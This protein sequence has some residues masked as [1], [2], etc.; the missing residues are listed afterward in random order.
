MKKETADSFYIQTSAYPGCIELGKKIAPYLAQFDIESATRAVFC[1]NSWH[2]NRSSQNCAYALNAALLGIEQ[3]GSKAITAYDSFCEFY[4]SISDIVTSSFPEDEVLP[5][6][7]HT[8]I[9]FHGKWYK[10]LHGCGATLEYPRLF[11]ADSIIEDSDCAKEFTEMLE[12]VEKMSEDLDGGGWRGKDDSASELSLPSKEYWER[13][14]K[15]MGNNPTEPLSKRAI[16]TISS[17]PTYVENRQFVESNNKIIPLFCPSLLTDYLNYYTGTN[18]LKE[19][20]GAINKALLSQACNLYDS[21]DQQSGS[22]VAYPLFEVNEEPIIGCPSTFLVVSE[23]K[24]I[25]LFYN[26]SMGVD[27]SGL[28]SL[29]QLFAKETNE[30]GI[31]DYTIKRGKRRKLI[32]T[33]PSKLKLTIVAYHDNVTMPST[34]LIKAKPANADFQCGAVEI[35]AI[36]LMAKDIAEISS[37]FHYAATSPS[38]RVP[39]FSAASDHFSLWVQNDRHIVNGTEDRH[40]NLFL[41]F[42][43]N[44]TDRYFRDFFQKKILNYPLINNR[45]WLLESPFALHFR[46]NERG[47]S[48]IILKKNGQSEGLLKKLPGAGIHHACYLHLRANLKSAE[49]VPL[50]KAEH[51]IEVFPLLQDLIMCMAN[52]LESELGALISEWGYLRLEYVM[53]GGEIAGGIQTIDDTLAIKGSVSVA[54]YPTVM[55]SA[56]SDVFCIALAEAR[57]R[58]IE[59]RLFSAIISLIPSRSQNAVETIQSKLELLSG[60]NKMVDMGA[61]ELPYLWHRKSDQITIDNAAKAAALKTVAYAIEDEGIEPGRYFGNDAN[62]AIRRFQNSLTESFEN[63]LKKFTKRDLLIKLYETL[64]DYSHTYYV[65][66]M[67]F[68]SFSNLQTEEES[69]V[70]EQS[71]S[72]RENARREMRAVMFSIETLLT[73]DISGDDTASKEDIARLIAIGDQL[74]SASDAADMLMFNPR[75][76]GI[77]IADNCVASIVEDEHLVKRSWDIRRRQILDRGHVGSSDTADEDYIKLSCKAFEAD[78]EIPFGFFLSVLDLLAFNDSNSNKTRF[79]SPNVISVDKPAII[80]LM[81]EQF[82]ESYSR[83]TLEKCIDFLTLDNSKLKYVG[84]REVDYLPF[85]RMKDRPNR[86]ELKPLVTFGNRLYYSPVQI[87]L[88]KRRWMQG[89]AERFIPAK[90]AFN[91]LNSVM[92]NWKRRY[93]KALEKDV[94]KCFIRKGFKPEHVFRGLELHKKG[95]HPRNLGDYDGLAYDASSETIWVIECKEFEKIESAFDY[96]QLQHRWFGEKGKLLHFERRIKYLRDNLDAVALDLG[97]EHCEELKIQAYLVSNKIFTN[98]IGESSF[99][100]ISLAELEKLLDAPKQ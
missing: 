99:Q 47:F 77:E 83:S 41:S 5:V 85:G 7:G 63:Q 33:K 46:D 69:R 75:N 66:T 34:V 59:C 26:A 55:F 11:F 68:T 36:L 67:R 13:V 82:G 98:V 22:V 90:K 10:A 62:N 49:G 56:S 17:F 72:R 94:R 86:F 27:D 15:W 6:M 97:F 48:E 78:T 43:Y 52:S 9:P 100:V 88:L 40:G 50:D 25:T 87:G 18:A 81:S 44:E 39:D 76:M 61:L 84:D 32:V 53:P 28:A 21:D 35:M 42:D 70:K 1:I 92:E 93:E 57:D 54:T 80:D 91:S 3:F 74:L 31:L 58:S 2:Q 20:Q 95:S 12:Y 8:L 45:N 79:E 23:E 24:R 19:T 73:L 89:I 16:K 96:M 37:F 38:K 4:S 29:K 65:D 51:E 14:L 64:A 71:L 60:E 30:V